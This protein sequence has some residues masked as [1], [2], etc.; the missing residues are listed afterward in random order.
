MDFDWNRY[1]ICQ[2]DRAE[3]LKCPLQSPASSFEKEAVYLSFLD[4]VKELSK[5][6]VLPTAVY[7]GDNVS[8]PDLKA[9]RGTNPVT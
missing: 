8:A 5:L 4:N 2:K 7:F 1:I 3:P 9:H 6:N